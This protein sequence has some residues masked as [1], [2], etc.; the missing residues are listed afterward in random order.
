[1]IKNERNLIES[2][3][4]HRNYLSTKKTGQIRWINLERETKSGIFK[5]KEETPA[6]LVVGIQDLK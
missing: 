4:L 6:Y 1:M 5:S 3:T 2:R